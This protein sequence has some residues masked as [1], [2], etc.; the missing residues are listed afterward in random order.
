MSWWKELFSAWRKPLNDISSSLQET[1]SDSLTWHG[2]P[3]EPNEK[4]VS[5]SN[6]AY[7][8]V[9]VGDLESAK[10][11]LELA[12]SI[13]PK[14]CHA[15]N[16]LAHIYFRTG[17][18]DLGE[19]SARLAIDCDPQNPKFYNNLM[20]NL[21]GQIKTFKTKKEVAASVKERLKQIDN[22]IELHPNYPAL[23][24]T[25][26]TLLALGGKSQAVWE[27]ELAIAQGLYE[28]QNH[29]PLFQVEMIIAQNKSV[30]LEMAQHWQHL[31]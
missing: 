7:Y 26:A 1:N 31:S 8:L 24:L 11:L 23:H 10:K 17:Q 18:F 13:D 28:E 29:I 6:R 16:E 19:K 22:T 25:K 30:C 27:A 15:H 12:I 14:Y 5:L 4:A 3:Y 20:A 9:E 2:A 21:V